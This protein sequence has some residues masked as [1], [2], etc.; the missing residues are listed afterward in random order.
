M[1]YI[2]TVY[3]AEQSF[4][5]IQAYCTTEDFVTHENTMWELILA[6]KTT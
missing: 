2:C 5:Q 4:W 1:T 6:M 3:E